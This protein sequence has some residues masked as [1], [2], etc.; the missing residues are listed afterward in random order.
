VYKT[1]AKVKKSLFQGLVQENDLVS[2]ML[3]P[4]LLRSVFLS[5]SLMY[6]KERRGSIGLLNAPNELKTP[7]KCDNLYS[8]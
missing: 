7:T 2:S 3:I 8:L 1:A 5:T 4:V 6:D